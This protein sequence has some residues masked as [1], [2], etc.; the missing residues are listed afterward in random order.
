[1]QVQTNVVI[2]KLRCLTYN[3][4]DTNQFNQLFKKETTG[5]IHK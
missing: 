4:S 1:M 5:T 2:S 3:S